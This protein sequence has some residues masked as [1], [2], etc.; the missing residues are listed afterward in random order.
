MY[1]KTQHLRQKNTAQLMIITAFVIAM[2]FLLLA[3]LLNLVIYAENQAARG[4][5]VAEQSAYETNTQTEDSLQKLMHKTNRQIITNDYNRVYTSYKNGSEFIAGVQKISGSKEKQLIQTQTE[6][7]ENG[8]RLIQDT[9]RN[10]T[11]AG[12]STSWTVVDDTDSVREMRQDVIQDDLYT[13]SNSSEAIDPSLL[14]VKPVFN[15]QFNDGSGTWR[16]YVLNRS[17]N[18]SIYVHVVDPSGASYGTC[19]TTSANRAVID[20][21]NRTFAGEDC[22]A[23]DFLGTL[24]SPY[25]I[26]YQDAD[27]V[28]GQYHLHVSKDYG[29]LSG[30]F[31]SAG[32][33]DSPYKAASVYSV[34]YTHSFTSNRID[35]T[36]TRKIAPYELR[37]DN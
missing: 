37:D 25:Q 8:T 35:Y 1:R 23:L 10:F 11:S 21:S 9:D 19:N 18:D 24:S 5:T 20:Y 27:N 14:S 32:T 4:L 29:A 30:N 34:T 2:T 28:G 36:T 33:T 22:A 16:V 15:T 26:A 6:T 13:H 31:N 12:N 3:T 17:Y 7:V